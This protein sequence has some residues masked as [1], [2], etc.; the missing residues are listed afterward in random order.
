MGTW[1]PWYHLRI[2]LDNVFSH[3]N[4]I[5]TEASLTVIVIHKALRSLYSTKYITSHFFT[6]FLSF[7]LVLCKICEWSRWARRSQVLFLLFAGQ[8]VDFFFSTFG[9]WLNWSFDCCSFFKVRLKA[10][11]FEK[12]IYSLGRDD[13][14]FLGENFSSIPS[15]LNA[16]FYETDLFEDKDQTDMYLLIILSKIG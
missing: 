3:Y 1:P 14:W 16:L 5:F 10:G 2:K 11:C 9:W 13:L 12:P 8:H 4:E 15:R 6:V 7:S